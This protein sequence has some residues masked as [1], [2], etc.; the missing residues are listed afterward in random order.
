MMVQVMKL[1]DNPQLSS[2]NFH[3]GELSKLYLEAKDNVKFLT[4]LE[5]H[6]KHITD[7]SYQTIL[8]SMQS[9]VNGLRM[10]WVISRHYNTDERMAPLM[11]NI[12]ETL[13]KRV[14]D[15]IK[16]SEILQMDFRTSRRI[17]QEARD[18]LTQWSEQ[19]FRM[20]KRIEDS[21]SDHRWEFDRKAL[22]GKTDYISEVCANIFEIIEALDHFRVFLG[23]ELKAVTGD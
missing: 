2:F 10:V 11:E 8:E 17:V 1:I 16:L 12:A 7:G 9:M 23:S 6:F 14:R 21:G 13:A 3:F 15:G 5:R 18:V 20:R 22:F 4:T 19:Y